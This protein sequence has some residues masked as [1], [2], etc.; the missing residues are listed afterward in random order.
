MR[1][2]VD[3]DIIVRS[4]AAMCEKLVYVVNGE[5]Y[6]TK[7]TAKEAAGGN[8][9]M[10]EIFVEAEPLENCLHSV[11]EM[12]ATIVNN[13]GATSYTVYLSAPRETTFRSKLFPEYKAHRDDRKP[14]HYD[15]IKDYL[16]DAH[17][18]II[19]PGLEADDA[20]GI[21]QCSQKD[22]TQTIICTLDKDLD[23]IPGWHYKWDIR[24]KG[25]VVTPASRYYIEPEEA[26]YKLWEQVLVGDAGDNIPGL[27]KT[28]GKRA[29]KKIKD[30]LWESENPE[31]YV[32]E[33]YEG[34]DLELDLIIE[35]ISILKEPLDA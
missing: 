24:R 8:E 16:L 14:V 2:L 18:A 9:D 15:A 26:E 30:G 31:Q 34:H 20:I 19:V 29:T 21:E 17:N 35:L 22:W 25:E 13:A 12:V 6:A 5:P 4:V 7:G 28:T 32:R 33:L 27:Y 11:K 23:T 1:A 3:G 10:V